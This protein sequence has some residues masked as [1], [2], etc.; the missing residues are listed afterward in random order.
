M[1]KFKGK[2][3]VLLLGA[4]KGK[5]MNLPGNKVLA[6]LG[7]K[8]VLAWSLELFEKREEIYEII[9]AAAEEDLNFCRELGAGYSKFSRVAA[10]GGSRQES[11]ANCLAFIS[12]ECS[13]VMVHDGARPFVSDYDLDALFKAAAPGYGAVLAAP[14]KNTIKEADKEG[15]IRR[16]LKREGLYQAQTPQLFPKKE[17]LKAYKDSKPEELASATDDASLLE[18]KGCPIKIALGGYKNI[19]LTTPED[20]LLARA[21]LKEEV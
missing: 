6:D 12:G 4:G 9:L 18:A 17:F 21:L 16:T 1:Q 3:S 10:G 19:K 11:V 5:R 2:V 7:G 20:L 8:P 15:F 14:E 13:W